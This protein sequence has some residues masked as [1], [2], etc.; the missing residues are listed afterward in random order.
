MGMQMLQRASQAE[1]VR[2]KKRGEHI[3]I[4]SAEE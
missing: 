2:K 4:L 1:G 3:M